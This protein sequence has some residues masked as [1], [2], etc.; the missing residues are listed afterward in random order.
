MRATMTEHTS[1]GG[2]IPNQLMN[3][4]LVTLEEVLGKGGLDSILNYASLQRFIGNYP[5]HDYRAEQELSDLKRLLVACYD[6][7]GE[8][9]TKPILFLSGRRAIQIV[10]ERYPELLG[11]DGV[12]LA[13]D[14]GDNRF[15]QYVAVHNRLI[16]ASNS[17]FGNTH[18]G[19]ETEEGR[20]VDI[21][22]CVFCEGI[23]APV[24]IC[25]APVGTAYELA[26]RFLGNDV[27]VQ[28][29]LCR[30]RGDPYCR[31][32]IRRPQTGSPN[33]PQ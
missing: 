5:P 20:V 11:L 10:V 9:T 24:P 12:A 3:L 19:Y 29:T 18:N 14:G 13:P 22:H 30:A 25:S 15:E 27:T 8:K 31:I 6:V 33:Q 23:T 7:I 21:S 28:E 1:F 4:T 16:A 26:R 32:L 2:K 17:L